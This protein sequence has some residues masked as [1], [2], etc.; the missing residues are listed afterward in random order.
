MCNPAR[1]SGAARVELRVR[2]AEL[3]EVNRATELVRQA[4]RLI[5][6]AE[7][8][9]WNMQVARELRTLLLAMPPP[10]ELDPVSQLAAE[11]EARA[12]ARR[13]GLAD[14]VPLAGRRVAGG[15][16]LALG[17]NWDGR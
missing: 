5:A 17:E 9:P 12:A 7:S 15:R 14:V 8:D 3:A 13:A 2:V 6:A 10:E 1:C 16:E 11:V 4:A